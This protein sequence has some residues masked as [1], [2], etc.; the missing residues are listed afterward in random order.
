MGKPSKKH[1]KSKKES[2]AV[3]SSGKQSSIG[4]K[5][6]LDKPNGFKVFILHLITI[7]SILIFTNLP[8]NERW[9]EQRVVKYLEIIPEQMDMIDV[10][11][12]KLAKYGYEYKIIN[13]L[14][15]KLSSNDTLLF[16]PQTY[17]VSKTFDRI[18]R[19][20]QWTFPAVFYYHSNGLMSVNMQNT[21]SLINQATHAVYVGNNNRIQF[22]KLDSKDKLNQVKNEFSK[23]DIDKVFWNKRQAYKYYKK[24][25]Q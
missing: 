14:K 20:H 9:L 10:E 12:R 5:P 15:N 24:Q 17:L 23:Y 19:S 11:K 13:F 16:P 2:G 21:D 1:K 4:K 22:L 18:K 8:L 6:L 3:K 7:A 25:Q